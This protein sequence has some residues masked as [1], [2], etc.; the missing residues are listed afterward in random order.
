[1]EFRSI[2]SFLFPLPAGRTEEKL[3][4]LLGIY[5]FSLFQGNLLKTW[6]T[7]V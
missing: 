4:S 5:I 6:Y 7:P 3:S 1:M 2:F